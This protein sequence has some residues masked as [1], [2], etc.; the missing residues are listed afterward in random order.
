MAPAFL[1][2]FHIRF[3]QTI[4]MARKK[5]RAVTILDQLGHRF[6]SFAASKREFSDRFPAMAAC[7]P[8]QAVSRGPCGWGHWS[9]LLRDT[10]FTHAGKE[11]V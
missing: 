6:W 3:S 8:S 10:G 1:S 4:P 5:R 7:H 11:I 9:P 2:W